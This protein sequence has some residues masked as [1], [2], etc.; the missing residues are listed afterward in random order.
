MSANNDR[1][2]ISGNQGDVI[3]VGIDGNGN[4]I[5][6]NVVVVVNEF[7]QDCGLTLLPP[8]HFKENNDID[9]DLKRWKKGFPFSLESIYHQN[10]YR[11]QKIMD[12]IK[13]KLQDK[14]RIL[15]LGESGTSKTTILM[16][17][18]CDYFRDGHIILY[19]IGRDTLRNTDTIVTKIKGLVYA[20]NKIL[21]AVDDVQSTKTALIFDIIDS[22][23]NLD[24]NLKEKIHFLL[25]ARQPEFDWIIEKNLFE[26]T[27]TIEIIEELFDENYRYQI[28]YFALDE[29]KEFIDKYKKNKISNSNADEIFY[30]TQGYPIMVKFAVLNEGLKVHVEKMY[31]QY[32]VE[33]S[34]INSK[35]LQLVILNSLFDISTVVLK[36]ELLKEFGLLG[37][38]KSIRGSIIKQFKGIWKTINPKWDIEFFRYIFSLEYDTA[39]VEKSFKDAV[40]D[41]VNN[42]S[43]SGFDKLYIYNTI[44]FTFIKTNVIEL[45]LIEELIDL[46][47]IESQLD[48]NH[49]ILFYSTIIGLSYQ[50]LEKDN[51]AKNYFDKAIELNPKNAE[52]HINKGI[53]LARMG[54]Y[55]DAI[56]EYDKALEINPYKD[57]VYYNKGISLSK[58]GNYKDAIIE[59][60]KALEINPNFAEAYY[61]KGFLLYNLSLYKDSISNFDIALKINSDYIDAL[62]GKSL[63]LIQLNRKDE[64]KNLID[65]V[66]EEDSQNT[67]ALELK[68]D[69]EKK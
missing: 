7:S 1:I 6:K 15:L 69:I 58:L 2:N 29:I 13:N 46:K 24:E 18:I 22:I 8:N 61:N 9:E 51:E 12:E 47:D 21:V 60:D 63:S 50:Y 31:H 56:I 38:A 30:E 11:R 32:I 26:D 33:K 64:A 54:K 41:I 23:K 45:E 53:S 14:K 28:P 25:V 34:I 27:N 67:V 65:N 35:K 37:V 10:E 43:I 57:K 5:W 3:G 68:K 62:L 55:K 66:L 20:G 40:Y 52:A 16:E 59:C 49:K 48:D 19:N 42:Q 44:Y 4:I 17:V 39:V 36:D